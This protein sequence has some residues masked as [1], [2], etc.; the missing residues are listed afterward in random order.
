MIRS[1]A[2]AL[3]AV[4]AL[5]VPSRA[6]GLMSLRPGDAPPPFALPDLSGRQVTNAEIAGAPAVVLFW[7][8]W[9]PRS[10]EMLDD[11]KR[12]AAAYGGKGLKLV[13]INIDG[14]S[15]DAGRKAA[16]R[17]FAAA[18]EL[19]FPV[20]LDE[21]LV[22]FSAWGVMAHP[23]EVVLGSDGRIAYVL[24]GYPLSLREELEEAVKKVLGIAVA[25]RSEPTT[26]VGPAPKGMALQH[27]NLGRQLLAKG[28]PDKALEAFRRSAAADP[29]FIE[30][31]VMVARVSLATGDRAP[32]EQLAGQVSPDAVNRGDLRY[33]LG[34][35]M[36]A[37]GEQDAAERAF[38]ELREQ[39]PK[40]EWGAWGLGQ[41]ALA[42]GD[43][44]A[45][46]ALFKDARAIQ[47]ANLEGE[48]FV[49][50]YFRD[51]WMRRETSPEDDAFVAVF[52]ALGEMRERFRNLY[53]APKV[54]AP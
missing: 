13:A 37:K 51:R 46:L 11:F 43:R 25:V 30:A 6:A 23:T 29:G 9:S 31:A 1:V 24:P 3:M 41:V 40:E 28:D 47:A 32:A 38:T 18:R 2:A 39:L 7:S 52:P 8:T 20:L 36:L 45:A 14:E 5:T 35:L 4:L 34:N 22:T 44:A 50:R 49:R 53:G 17:E 48:T 19:P 33:L 21:G 54:A 42:R 10:A 27:F 15:L 26:S 16:I 12:H